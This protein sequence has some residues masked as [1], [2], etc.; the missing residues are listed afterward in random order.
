M[1]EIIT[2]EVVDVAGDDS[3]ISANVEE[4]GNENL[5]SDIDSLDDPDKL[6]TMLRE[7]RQA[8]Q[9]AIEESRHTQSVSDRHYNEL[10]NQ[11][12]ELRG[13]FTQAS[14]RDSNIEPFDQSAFDNELAERIAN[15]T[16]GRGTLSIMREMMRE[17]KDDLYKQVVGEVS[18]VKNG[19][20]ELN[21]TYR[22]NKELVD[23]ICSKFKVSKDVAL[24]IAKE[25]A[26]KKASQPG[27]V[28][29]PGRIANNTSTVSSIR[30]KRRVSELGA[31]PV[32]DRVAQNILVK[33][34]MSEDDANDILYREQEDA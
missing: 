6:R 2:D 14:K 12:A 23:S 1:P 29:A 7:E 18:S 30:G 26:P 9:K 27:K 22:E 21:P 3:D 33:L 16:D 17:V 31:S 20:L 15:D 4:L 24:E 19:V 11:M 32:G 13:M 10:S 5:E 34:N 28:S 8:R 25:Y